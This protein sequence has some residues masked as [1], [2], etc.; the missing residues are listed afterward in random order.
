LP[1]QT[2]DLIQ[3]TEDKRQRLVVDRE[4]VANLEDKLDPGDVN[5]AKYPRSFLPFGQHPAV[6]DPADEFAPIQPLQLVDQFIE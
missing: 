5:L 3:Q 4:A 6:L 2:I 1:P